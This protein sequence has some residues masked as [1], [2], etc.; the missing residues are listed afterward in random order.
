[1]R[2]FCCGDVD[3]FLAKAGIGVLP[4]GARLRRRGPGLL[5]GRARLRTA[6][7]RNDLS[8]PDLLPR[9]DR[10]ALQTRLKLR[11]NANFRL[12]DNANQP[13]L[14]RLPE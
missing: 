4:V 5:H 7:H 8:R 14:L 3:L 12:V 6:Q 2:T 10:N 11:R 1:M 13:G 9:R